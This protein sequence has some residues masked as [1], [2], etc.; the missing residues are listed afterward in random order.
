MTIRAPKLRS[1]RI[2]RGPRALV[3]RNPDVPRGLLDLDEMELL[4][5]TLDRDL[6]MLLKSVEHEATEYL[7][8]YDRTGGAPKDTYTARM[9]EHLWRAYELT[10]LSFALYSHV[11]EDADRDT[12]LSESL[13]DVH[14]CIKDLPDTLRDFN[15][16]IYPWGITW[17]GADRFIQQR[18]VIKPKSALRMLEMMVSIIY[19]IA[20]GQYLSKNECVG[21]SWRDLL[22]RA[23]PLLRDRARLVGLNT[24][25]LKYRDE[26]DP[27]TIS[28]SELDNETQD[29]MF[30]G[31]IDRAAM[32]MEYD[33]PVVTEA[34]MG[35]VA[36]GL[37]ER[38]GRDDAD[39]FYNDGF[40]PSSWRDEPQ[41]KAALDRLAT[42]KWSDGNV[43]QFIFAYTN[44]ARRRLRDRNREGE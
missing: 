12:I 9:Q 3:R 24:A 25:R 16:S 31:L 36:D 2:T 14:A 34:F 30:N 23:H 6:G 19:S 33:H 21:R 27:E 26:V 42:R 29:A 41:W 10:A 39:D 38:M 44:A 11:S 32:S 28:E 15:V 13:A 18:I 7:K 43:S 8:L 1:T 20:G 40:S 35:G 4:P 5:E 17:T 22:L 37:G